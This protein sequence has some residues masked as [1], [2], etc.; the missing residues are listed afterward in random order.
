MLLKLT[1]TVLISLCWRHVRGG[2][3]INFTIIEKKNN[4]KKKDLASD[5]IRA[6][7]IYPDQEKPGQS[8]YSSLIGFGPYRS[9]FLLCQVENTADLLTFSLLLKKI[10]LC[11]AD[12]SLWISFRV[13]L[14]FYHTKCSSWWN[15]I[16]FLSISPHQNCSMT[17]KFAGYQVNS[18]PSDFETKWWF[19]DQVILVNSG[20]MAWWFLD[21]IFA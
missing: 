16:F 2:V 12:I 3:S 17:S 10:S 13:S 21:Q 18:G 19:W 9:V 11:H 7:N 15:V 5:Q 20:P 6:Y 1:I 4:F 8:G 14:F